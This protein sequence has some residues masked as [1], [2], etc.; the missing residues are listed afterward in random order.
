MQKKK[1]KIWNQR[2]SI[3][4]TRNAK[5]LYIVNDGTSEKISD[6][7]LIFERYREVVLNTDLTM[8]F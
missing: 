8:F 1:K 3:L 2:S 5:I 7:Q 6:G 4:P